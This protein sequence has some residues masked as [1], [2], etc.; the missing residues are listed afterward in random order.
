[1]T[2]FTNIG[3]ILIHKKQDNE[4]NEKTMKIKDIYANP[5]IKRK[6]F[7]IIFALLFAIAASLSAI[8]VAGLESSAIRVENCNMCEEYSQAL[9]KEINSFIELDSDPK[10][11]VS[12]QVTSAINEYRKEIID[13]Q[14]HADVEKRSLESEILLA[15]TKGNAAG[16]LAWV[17]YYNIYTFS[18]DASANKI[19]AKYAS[20]ATSIKNST[21]HT[22]LSAECEVML[23][24]LN[25]LIFTE[26]AQNLALP[27]DSLSASALISGTVE[28]FKNLY[29]ADLFGEAYQAGYNQ[30]TNDLGL[31]RIRDALKSEAESIFK[32]IRPSEAF[33][34]SPTASLLVYDLKNAQSA[35]TMNNAIIEF[36]EELLAIDEKKPY[37]SVAKNEY[38]TL[39]KTAA[40]RAT[41]NQA[42]A[43]LAEIFDGYSLTIKKSEIKDSVYALFLGDKSAT[44]EGLLS[45]EQAYNREG[46]IIDG[47]KTDSEVEAELVN[48]KA[49]LFIYKHQEI[50]NNP[51][52]ELSL[53]DENYATSAI[54]EYSSLENLVKQRLVSEINIIAEKYNS[55]LIKRISSYLENDS[56]YL[57]FCEIIAEEI[58]S[59]SRESIDDFY[60]KVSKLPQKAEALARVIFEYRAIL[61][62][63]NYSGYTDSEKDALISILNELSQRLSEID[64][65][66]VAIYA[67]EISDARSS[68]IRSLNIIDQ[69]ARVR[70][71]TRSSQ[72]EEILNELKNA[73][74]KI[75]LCS[76][77]S[78][79][80]LQASRAIYKIERLL[81]SDAIINSCNK[82][83]TD[84]SAMEFLENS[85]RDAFYTRINALVSKAK[86][87][88]EAENI[89]ALESIWNSFSASL[90][91][92]QS[93]AQA[94]DLS[95]AIGV[96]VQKITDAAKSKLEELGTLE[97][98]SAD[99]CEEIYN[100][101]K[102]AE[103]LAKEAVPLAK[104]TAEVI[105]EY[106][107][108]LE[109]INDLLD[110]AHQADLNGYKNYL[111]LALDE[112]ENIKANYSTENY[113]KISKIIQATIDK[114]AL[115]TTK[116][117]CDSILLSAQNE[118]L[119][120][121]DLLDDEKDIALSS[122]LSLL[123][124]L[125]KDSPLYSKDNFSK[126]EGLYDEAK[127]EIGKIS[128]ISSI[129]L[130]KQTLSK[131][132]TLICSVRKDS[133][134]TS[135]DA[136][137]IATPSLQYPNGYDYSKGLLGSI[138]LSNGLISDA[139]L[140]VKLL[141]LSRNKQVE[142]L[143]RSSA[144]NGSLITFEKLSS[145]TARLLRS[146]SIAATLDISLSSI[147]DSASGYTLQILIPNELC[148]EN[149]LGLAFVKGDSVEFYPI[150]QADSL[151]SA[152]LDHFSKYYI[153]VE[154][155]LNVQPL[156]IA[157]I[158]LLALEFLVLIGIIYLRYKRKSAEAKDGS[159][160]LPELP[161]SGIIPFTTVLTRVYPENGVSLA[162]L[163]SV[164]A[165]ALASTIVLLVYKE[166]KESKSNEQRLLNGRG[167][168]PLL[169]K[170]K[171]CEN[172]EE[173]FF[174]Y[175]DGSEYCTVGTSIR[176]RRVRAEVDLDLISNSF[177]S[178]EIVNLER[179][180]Q[181]G[182]VDEDTEYVKILTKGNLIKPLT[183]EANEFSNAAKDIVELSGG[184]VRKI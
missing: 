42:A 144:K 111:L 48:A 169:G 62:D 163:L 136:H 171:E 98:I 120:I 103:A 127:I 112:Y 12:T 154:S 118:I 58:K 161:M 36:I 162:I 43:S 167:E 72:N 1:M 157:L 180:K 40:S 179:L 15:Y 34:S 92:I 95:R 94:I 81:T 132:I 184:R 178:G 145:S 102:N 139:N 65:S 32:V 115:A 183:I 176:A 146:A 47:C 5:K 166:A 74:E 73:Q 22:V 165:L 158:I 108:F 46:G 11:T 155:T 21:Q 170:G 152:R 160:N 110:L 149:I 68:A 37:S 63:Q 49:A 97:Y 13:L 56:L 126:I 147:D 25:R 123:E 69:S 172:S 80:I 66:D 79:M 70:I 30:L 89:S 135:E 141:E 106:A 67:D 174:N 10:K 182:L 55:I 52:D 128:D 78:E 130:V 85:E 4:R 109:A 24:E 27:N 14:S 59:T 23:N 164:A 77:K 125:K 175:S 28:A 134:Y 2:I 104:S 90:N 113:N 173:L 117:E 177:K 101:I 60:N 64:P 86:N 35:K 29:S 7:A 9:G 142:S 129:A 119:L 44:D 156:L 121:N 151:I 61:A 153:V 26:R 71:A 41:E 114:L 138:H 143:L 57:D 84:I 122:L 150:K 181:K 19:S 105:T 93:E 20:F 33:S 87:A 17:Y 96:Y 54:I 140:S 51:F 88:R 99:K 100:N 107:H 53:N 76:E 18:S 6:H 39:C 3:I 131:Y 16:R 50:L 168:Q 75:A 137:I 159:I 83:K 31:Q 116:E 38:L 8:P 82:F 124:S 148:N 133:I 91:A 45:L